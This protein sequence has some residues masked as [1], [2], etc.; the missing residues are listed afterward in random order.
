[1]TDAA[2]QLVATLKDRLR[3]PAQRFFGRGEGGARFGAILLAVLLFHIGVVAT[4][5]LFDRLA[6]SQTPAEESVV[7][8]IA[9]PPPPPPP[10]QAEAQPPKPEDSPPPEEK[11]EEAKKPPPPPPK[12]ATL[13][14]KPAVDAPRE[15]SQEKQ[16]RESAD[17]ENGAP[18]QAKSLLEQLKTEQPS[19][20]G[21]QPPAE[22]KPEET[23]KALDE[24]RPDA[25]TI[26]A[27]AQKPQQ[28]PDQKPAQPKKAPIGAGGKSVADIVASLAP[29]PEAKFGAQTKPSPVS[30]GSAETTYLTI[31]YGLIMPKFH[32]S[33]NARSAR[34]NKGVITFYIDPRGNLVHQAVRQ[35]TG[36]AEMDAAALAAVRRAAPFPPPPTSLPVGIRWEY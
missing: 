15:Q 7:E 6:A 21:A 12:T 34:L 14:E 29:L 19:D 16:K 10:P 22:Q 18:K 28:K 35:S 5:V 8:V 4:L 24:N 36:V 23:A 25:E 20:P 11:K 26:D 3:A 13:D 2:S 31:L 9:E 32:A 17:K 33:A 27:A 30:G 1:M